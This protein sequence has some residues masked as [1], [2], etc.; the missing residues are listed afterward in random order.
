MKGEYFIVQT[1]LDNVIS[2]LVNASE[3]GI[4][5]GNT[6]AI[7]LTASLMAIALIRYLF[8]RGN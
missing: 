7:A 8:D 6:I 3:Q 4:E 5:W 1:E 2:D